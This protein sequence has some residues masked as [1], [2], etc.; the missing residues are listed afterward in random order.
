MIKIKLSNKW[1][2]YF[3]SKNDIDKKIELEI[4]IPTTV[5]EALI[6]NNIINDPF[7]GLNEHEV[8]WVYE[9]DWIYE[10]R[11]DIN[12]DLLDNEK[13]IIRF[14]GLDTLTDIY[15]NN[16][17]LGSTN[18]MFRYYD[19]EVKSIM[20][21]KDNVLKIHFFSPTHFCAEKVQENGKL[22][23][24]DL[25]IP[26]IQYLRKAQYSFG[27]DWGPKLPDIG[28]WKEVELIGYDKIKIDSFY[29]HQDFKYNENPLEINN[30]DL[31]NLNIE[32]VNIK[33]DIQ[34]DLDDILRSNKKKELEK[35]H[36]ELNLISPSG[37]KITD[38]KSVADDNT[39]FN[40][41]IDNP[42][43]WWI[44]ELG[45]PNL[46]DLILN[47]KKEDKIIETVSQ[48]IGIRDI[49][50]IL[51]PDKWGES[52]YFLLNGIPIFAKGANWIP[53]DN[54]LTRGKKLGVYEKF[55]KSIKE[56]NINMLRVWGGGIYEYDTFYELCDY[57]GI[58]VWQDF[59]F[60]CGLYP[61]KKEFFD[62]IKEEAIQNIKRIRNHPCI[63]LWC[64]S[65]EDEW[66]LGIN[67]LLLF[68]LKFKFKKRKKYKKAYFEVF[69]GLLPNLISEYDP[70]HDYW[71]SSPS[72]G[73]MFRHDKSRGLLKSNS[74]KSG[75]SHFWN[76]WHRGKPITA[77]RKFTPRFM[78]EFGFQSFP[79]IKTIRSFCPNEELDFFS[80]ILEN[81]Q[82][83]QTSMLI[84][85]SGNSKI[86]KYMKRRYLI[87]DNFEKQI[88]LSQITQAEAIEYGIEHWRRNR[89]DKR[90]M[91]ALYWQLNDCWP[92]ISWS[93]IDYFGRWK[94]LQYIIKRIFKPI[95]PSVLESKNNVNFYVSNDLPDERM[96]KFKWKIVNSNGVKK[97]DG[98]KEIK[99]TACTSI[100]ID[101][102]DLKE[103]NNKSKSLANYIIFYSLFDEQDKLIYTGFRLFD[104]PK[105][106]PLK[107][108]QLTWEINK[109]KLDKHEITINTK[110]IALYVHIISNKFDFIASDNYFSLDKGESKRIIIITENKIDFDDLK[111]N[112][113]INSLY[114][115]FN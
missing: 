57:H 1:K 39:I 37:D 97:L 90:C 105:Y 110:E 58:L 33:I 47:L 9:S 35:Y 23:T 82:K 64:G 28:I 63:A 42:F 103:I 100:K 14:R 81:H 5:F 101:G 83:N 62:N 46:Y 67:L 84:F 96:V 43:L 65:N 36:L 51:K 98:S 45:T 72:N 59:M 114:D 27:W 104:C 19:F 44:H 50:L 20:K 15:L 56:S 34:L 54:F 111:S 49:K 113:K 16:E 53:I 17:K 109:L 93:S 18:N 95:F 91:G 76:V 108:P 66:F 40:L 31:P 80:P 85:K 70:Q 77:Y 48:K 68:S 22:Y 30:S 71:S 7:Y 112:L 115:L 10:T 32:K 86:M 26:G 89:N 12:H 3:V 52:F 99:I 6:E 2:L 13:I 88:I 102:V 24:D 74:P 60:A 29:L 79:S 4:K 94:A 78:S 55:L 106:F 73:A 25:G 8:S 61:P 41:S 69:E 107:P 87:P 92:A 21:K 11:F 38:Q 75:D